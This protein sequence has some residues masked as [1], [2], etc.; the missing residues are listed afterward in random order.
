MKTF[1]LKSLEI[2]ENKADNII[3]HPI[4]LQDGLI[5]NREDET[6]KWL[7]EAYID[8]SYFDYFQQLRKETDELMVQV[9]IT[10]KSNDPATFISSII[11]INKIN[12]KMNVL[13]MGTVIEFKKGEIENMLKTLIELGYQGEELLTEFKLL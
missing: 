12:S 9:K 10:K 4:P 11:D 6:N 7:I 2:I 3:R 5:I 13:L 1:K 8:H